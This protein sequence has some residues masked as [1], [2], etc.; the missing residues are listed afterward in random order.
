MVIYLMT[1]LSRQ[2]EPL[3]ARSETGTVVRS[4]QQTQKNHKDLFLPV[5]GYRSKKRESTPDGLPLLRATILSS[6]WW[7]S[8]S[9]RRISS[10]ICRSLRGAAGIFSFIMLFLPFAIQDIGSLGRGFPGLPVFFVP[11]LFSF[12]MN[13][14]VPGSCSAFRPG[15]SI[16]CT[17]P[18]F[19]LF[20]D[21][22]TGFQGYRIRFFAPFKN[23]SI[24]RYVTS[25]SALHVFG[26]A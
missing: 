12:T 9:C 13:A 5:P 19:H 11:V 20:Q 15:A 16:I 22:L 23:H 6:R 25:Q 26:P 7:I 8:G 1:C 18:R 10:M 3:S 24:A 17:D 4:P 2:P 14:C 21:L